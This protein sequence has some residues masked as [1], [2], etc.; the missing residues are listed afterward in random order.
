MEEITG[1]KEIIKPENLAYKKSS[2]LTENIMH[3]CPGCGH[4]TAH[5]ITG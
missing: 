1:I 2:L 3:Y 4:S 5:R